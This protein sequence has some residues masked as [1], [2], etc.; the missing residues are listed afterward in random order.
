MNILFVASRV[1]LD[2]VGGG[3]SFTRSCVALLRSVDRGAEV[4]ILALPPPFAAF[5]RAMRQAMAMGRAVLSEHSAK[6]HFVLP[7]DAD[8]R[9]RQAVA[10]WRP[11]LVVFNHSELMP[12]ARGLPDGL[13]AVLVAHNIEHRSLEA[14]ADTLRGPRAVLR[15]VLRHDA[16][17]LRRLE[18]EGRRIGN[19]LC[20]S[21]ECGPWFAGLGDAMRVLPIPPLFEY[22][23]YAGLR[24]SAAAPLH[25]GMVAKM[26]WW[27]NRRGAEW[28]LEEVLRQVPDGTVVAH[29]YGPG[30]EAFAGAHPNLVAHGRIPTLDEAWRDCHLHVCPIFEGSGAHVK[31]AEALYNGVPVIATPHAIRPFQV[32]RDQGVVELDGAEAWR[33]FLVSDAAM[34]MAERGVSPAARAH[35]AMERWIP[36]MQDFVAGIT[37][38]ACAPRRQRT[39][40]TAS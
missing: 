3:I 21:G 26:S 33:G 32:L 31:L 11:D 34:A 2:G 23:A 27:P 25:V 29:Y 1:H 14:M 19:V 5:P 35:F 9:L 28:F 17:K 38:T 37:P 40:S 6:S 12:L 7:A 24:P 36:D 39:R 13:P 10:D 30:S 18:E 22:A 15:P 8:R 4:R 20:I 16:T